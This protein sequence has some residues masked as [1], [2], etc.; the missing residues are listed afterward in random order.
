[1]DRRRV[2]AAGDAADIA[3]AASGPNGAVAFQSREVP[4]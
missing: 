3:A 4:L 1:M 2:A